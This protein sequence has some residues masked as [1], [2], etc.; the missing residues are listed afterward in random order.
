MIVEPTP[1][2]DVTQER[3]AVLDKAVP[4]TLWPPLLG[5]FFVDGSHEPGMEYA[6]IAGFAL[7]SWLLLRT[8][9]P[10]TPQ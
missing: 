8:G 1:F 4:A 10:T 2:G 3:I 6:A 7:K 9:Q 5:T